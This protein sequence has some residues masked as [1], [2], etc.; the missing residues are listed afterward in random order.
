VRS[1]LALVLTWLVPV[2]VVSA[3]VLHDLAKKHSFAGDFEQR[4]LSPSGD[5]I[6]TIG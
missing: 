3:D 5:V 1:L 4:V 2:T 6:E